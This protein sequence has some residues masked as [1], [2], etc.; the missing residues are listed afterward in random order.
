VGR[1]VPLLVAGQT[2][3]V[4]HWMTEVKQLVDRSLPAEILHPIR[5]F[6]DRSKAFAEAVAEIKAGDAGYRRY[7]ETT[8]VKDDK[9]R[10]VKVGLD[11]ADTAA[12]WARVDDVAGKALTAAG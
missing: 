3:W 9:L 10:K 7:A 5:G 11:D 2:K 6:R 8:I 12:F 1:R 4:K